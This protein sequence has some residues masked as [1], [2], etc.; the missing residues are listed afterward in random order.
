MRGGPLLRSALL[1]AG[2][3]TVVAL[4]APGAGLAATSQ[5]QAGDFN[6]VPEI[7]FNAFY[8]GHTT[9][10][11][12]SKITFVVA[13]FHTVTFPKKGAKLPP[14]IHATA[15]LNPATNDPGGAPYWW[16]GVTP[17]IEFN[18]GAVAPAGGT[19]V[20]GAKT[21]SSGLL[22]GNNPTFTVSFPKLGTFQ[23]RCLIHPN[24]KG[25]VTVVPATSTAA[26]T[27]RKLRNRAAREKARQR[28]A[29]DKAV[30]KAKATTGNTVIIS[31]G[32]SS[33]QEFAFFPGK[34]TV[35][36]G[37]S[38]TFKMGARNEVHTVTF[39]PQAF[40][41]NVSKK[42]FGGNS[43]AVGSEGFYPSDPPAAGAPVVTATAHGNGFV[44]S[45]MLSDPGTGI[46]AP[47]SFAVTF[48]QAGTFTFECLIHTEM[49]GTITVL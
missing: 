44:N 14:F 16:G 31:P 17:L 9:V 32:N 36:A 26:D 12:G 45:G 29:V 15:N 7:E 5:V 10:T 42:A 27:P 43:L 11:K 47:H 37:S 49:K 28:I 23:V 30:T 35:P 24:M 39:G 48:P 18:G 25:S 1:A 46:P 8:P 21:V 41:D 4:L 38:V 20:T 13:G 22:A 33:A 34:K 19:S 6:R 3:G 2:A 40:V